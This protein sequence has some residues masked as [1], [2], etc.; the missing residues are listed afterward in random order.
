[1]DYEDKIVEF[2][3]ELTQLINRYSLENRSNT[4]DFILA[5]YLVMCLV[6]V[7]HAIGVREAWYKPEEK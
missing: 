2:E 7:D 5:K 6:C 1:M 4:P 3:K